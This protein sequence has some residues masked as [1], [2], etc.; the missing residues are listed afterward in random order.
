MTDKSD[1]IDKKKNFWKIDIL[2]RTNFDMIIKENNKKHDP[3]WPQ[4]FSHSYRKVIT[5][6]SGSGKA[7]FIKFTQPSTRYW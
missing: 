6:G 5:R 1:K 3:N 4:I 2:K 7:N